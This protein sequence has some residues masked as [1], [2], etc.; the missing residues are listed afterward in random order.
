MWRKGWIDFLKKYPNSKIKL[1]GMFKSKCETNM[2][3]K[4]PILG[5]IILVWKF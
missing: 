3:Q 2:I 1:E 5:M 4:N